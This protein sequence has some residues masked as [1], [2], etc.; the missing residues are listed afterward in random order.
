LELE[1]GNPKAQ[2]MGIIEVKRL[3]TPQKNPRDRKKEVPPIKII[4]II[5]II[6]I[7]GNN[8][9]KVSLLIN[10]NNNNLKRVSNN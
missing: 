7:I 9:E 8:R 1:E 2:I 10:N 5:I 3:G 4:I 6:I